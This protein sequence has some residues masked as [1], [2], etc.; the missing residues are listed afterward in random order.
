MG[1]KIMDKTMFLL[2]TRRMKHG[3][4]S[5]LL[6]RGYNYHKN[7]PIKTLKTNKYSSK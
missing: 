1:Y 6:C 5:V 3:F 2:N 4:C 7:K